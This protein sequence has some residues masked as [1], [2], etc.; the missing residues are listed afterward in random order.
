MTCIRWPS[1][2]TVALAMAASLGALS[3][4]TFGADVGGEARATRDGPRRGPQDAAEVEAFLD[5]L[6]PLA[7]EQNH[8]AGA[9]VAVVAHGRLLVAKG[10]GHAD[11]ERRIPVDAEDTLFPIGSISKLFTATAVMQLVEQGALDLHADVN[12]YLDFE[13]PPTFPERITLGHLLTHT[14]GFDWSARDLL[15][16]DERSIVPLGRWLA[17]HVPARVRPPGVQAVYTNYAMALAGYAVE[18]VTGMAW[19]D[20]L[21]ERI[22]APLGMTRTTSRQ[23]VPARQP[24]HLARGYEFAQGRFQPRPREFVAGAAPAGSIVASATDMARFMLAHLQQGGIEG[25]SIAGRSTLARMHARAFGHDPR[26]PGLALGFYER[27]SHGLRIIGHGGATR[28]FHSDLALLPSEGVGLFVAFNT[29][30]GATLTDG[31]FLRAFLDHYYPSGPADI[32]ATQPAARGSAATAVEGEYRFNRMSHRTFEKAA[33][34]FASVRVRAS[35][36]G[37]LMLSSPLGDMRLLPIGPRLYRDE[38]GRDVVAFDTTRSKRASHAYVASVPFMALERVPWFES[39]RLHGLLLVVAIGVF[40]A[41]ILAAA[42]RLAR[43][44]GRRPLRAVQPGQGWIVGLA[45]AY[46]GFV[47]FLGVLAS[48]GYALLA[49]PVVRLRIALALPLVGAVLTVPATIH[50]FRHWQVRAGS[51]AGR[52]R[53][54]G[55][56]LVSLAFLGSLHQW[57]LLGWRL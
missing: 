48:D 11:V 46:T 56:V 47:V 45:L 8:V 55:V 23:P 7:L 28:W 15:T 43:R 57:N 25:A 20:Y 54:S 3:P 27:T 32:D 12:R 42:T 29:A 2:V 49:G 10:Y 41:T 34:L 5:R 30:Q 50:A 16:D 31:S 44:M 19:D 13:I 4:P 9:T 17:E 51:T 26:L 6:M 53:Y 24:G 22:L 40:F 1:V 38:R 18:R 33:A 35:R 37:S 14:A 52:L 39:A 36:D 21:E